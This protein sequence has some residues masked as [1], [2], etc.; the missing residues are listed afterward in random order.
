M[1]SAPWDRERRARRARPRR[2]RSTQPRPRRR[3]GRLGLRP[4]TRSRADF[5]E[6]TVVQL[7][8]RGKGCLSYVVGAGRARRRHRPLAR[9][10]PIRQVAR[11]HGWRITHVLDTHLHADHLSG[12]RELAG[13]TGASLWL[14]PADPFAFDFEPLADGK[15]DRAHARG[16][17]RV[18]SVSVP[19]HTE[20]STMYQLGEDA[21]F[22]G[23]TLFLESVGRPDLADEAEGYAHHLFH[24]LHDRVLPLSDAIMV[25]PAHFGPGVEVHAGMFVARDLG[26][27]LRHPPGLEFDEDEFVAVGTR[28]REGPAGQL[29]PDRRHQRWRDALSDDARRSRSDRTAARW[30]DAR[31]RGARA[32][33]EDARRRL[34]R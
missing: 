5:G 21:I 4:T 27:L 16:R 12:A 33:D 28:Q 34:K 24:S 13:E 9:L 11:R 32:R 23:D 7:R 2:A 10:A 20:G 14:N 1:W 17:S 22:T 3:H 19:G 29:P 25:F 8:R 26:E 15:T 6:A 30:R 18:A 31:G